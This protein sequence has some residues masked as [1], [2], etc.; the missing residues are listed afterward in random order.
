MADLNQLLG[1]VDTKGGL[2]EASM[3]EL[4]SKYE[5]LYREAQHQYVYERNA[6]KSTEGL[7]DFRFVVGIIRRNR[8]IIGSM[9]RGMR[10]LKTVGKYKFIEEDLP[11]PKPAPKRAR[12]SRETDAEMIDE[13]ALVSIAEESVE[14]TIDG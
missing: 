6:S 14:E 11:E 13:E 5:E 3:K 4:L 2:M 10:G 12:R 1:E 7:E 9:L 8:D